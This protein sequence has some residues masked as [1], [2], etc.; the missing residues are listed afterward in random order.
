MKRR[1]S[2]A[3]LTTQ[4]PQ[5]HSS[6]SSLASLTLKP[7]AAAAAL[8]AP[9]VPSS[10]PWYLCAQR[11]LCAACVAIHSAIRHIGSYASPHSS[12]LYT[13][14]LCVPHP[15]PEFEPHTH[16][17]TYKHT[18]TQPYPP[19]T[20]NQPTHIFAVTYFPHGTL[21][22]HPPSTTPSSP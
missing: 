11:L 22:V 8:A 17:R 13:Y 3:T 1:I 14:I 20:S 4:K 5:H 18:Q 9:S 21:G 2:N 15:F 10:S 7:A 6:V 19:C 12:I 16:I